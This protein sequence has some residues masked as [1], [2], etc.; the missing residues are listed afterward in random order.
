MNKNNLLYIIL[1]L[2]VAVVL[3][4]LLKPTSRQSQTYT[5]TEAS[6]SALPVSNIKTF[7]LVVKAKELVSGPEVL[8]V[9]KGDQVTI[10]ITSDE[11]EELHLH[12]YDKSVDLEANKKANITFTANLTGRF[13]YEL[14]QS[15]IEIGALEV[16]PK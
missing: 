9:I 6:S 3:F 7:D 1:T 4:Y 12:G 8:Q 14:E 10:N 16:Q 13:E 15:K 11:D 2:I 5:S